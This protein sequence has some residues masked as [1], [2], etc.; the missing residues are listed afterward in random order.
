MFL[1]KGGKEEREG[2]KREKVGKA[3]KE[4]KERKGRRKR[5]E[6][7]TKKNHC[8]KYSYIICASKVFLFRQ[9]LYNNVMLLP[10]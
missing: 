10:I 5:K 3:K 7:E 1:C 9:V 4:E 6:T 2:G 8:P